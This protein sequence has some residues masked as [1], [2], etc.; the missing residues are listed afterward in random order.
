MLIIRYK[1]GIIIKR[2]IE[3]ENHVR[4]GVLTSSFW[5][6]GTSRNI[7]Q[8]YKPHNEYTVGELQSLLEQLERI[9]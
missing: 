6:N 1:N 9:T 7:A 3:D 5:I 2:C 8:L 4:I